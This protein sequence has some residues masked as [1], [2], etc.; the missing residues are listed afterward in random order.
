MKNI[1]IVS[2]FLVLLLP[3]N[4]ENPRRVYE[5]K[6]GMYRIL[7]FP[8]NIRSTPGLTSNVIGRLDLHSEIEILEKTNVSQHIDGKTHY[9]YKIRYNNDTGYV[10][11]GLIA[12][13]SFAQTV[14]G[15]DI[16]IYY[17][18]SYIEGRITGPG[19]Q[20]DYY[21]PM[22]KPEDIFIYINGR[23]INTD[24]ISNIYTQT[25][26]TLHDSSRYYV[27]TDWH[28]ISLYPDGDI[29]RLSLTDRA[30]S[31]SMFT[32]TTDGVIRY[33]RTEI[34]WL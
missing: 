8:V 28:Y 23:R 3:I 10:W 34:G 5:F 25:Y 21:F 27:R 22:I 24:V 18:Y 14:N 33:I 1:L 15:Q 30:A 2:V 32:L 16:K 20:H 4:A 6:N 17:R 11:G 31:Y 9:W 26:F 19:G 29:I 7:D 12:V 13:E